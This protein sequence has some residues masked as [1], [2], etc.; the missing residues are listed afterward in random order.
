MAKGS[1]IRATTW[2]KH[3]K[4]RAAPRAATHPRGR[5]I[6]LLP[7]KA[8]YYTSAEL[9]QYEYMDAVSREAGGTLTDEYRDERR[10]WTAT[11]RRAAKRYGARRAKRRPK[12]VKHHK[13]G[14]RVKV[15]AYTRRA[16]GG[17]S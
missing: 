11:T 17:R 2:R 4:R 10:A 15:R 13:A 9:Q 14:G 6:G 5:R 1:P 12:L 7:L 8:P 16:P 3:L